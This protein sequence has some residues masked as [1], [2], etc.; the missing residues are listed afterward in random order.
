MKLASPE[1]IKA[2]AYFAKRYPEFVTIEPNPRT[3]EE[4][5]C[6]EVFISRRQGAVGGFIS[7]ALRSA[8]P[9]SVELIHGTITEF[10][11]LEQERLRRQRRLT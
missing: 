3:E 4:E 7:A 10:E 6:T 9:E 8:K 1:A 2:I 5:A 11:R